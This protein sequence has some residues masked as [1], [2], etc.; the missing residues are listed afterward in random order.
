MPPSRMGTA[1]PAGWFGKGLG[2]ARWE[3]ALATEYTYERV[4]NL[5]YLALHRLHRMYRN[6]YVQ[7]EGP[8]KAGN[9][10]EL[11]VTNGSLYERTEAGDPPTT[12]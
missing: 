8:K 12:R 1:R 5:R 9:F 6:S 7:V 11:Y 3:D 4:L 2:R 10:A